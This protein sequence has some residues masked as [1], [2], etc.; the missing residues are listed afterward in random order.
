MLFLLLMFGTVMLGV[1]LYNFN[2]TPYLLPYLRDLLADYAL[3]VAVVAFSFIGSFVFSDIQR[4]ALSLLLFMD[5]NISAAMVNKL[6][7]G[8]AYHLDLLVVGLLN[9]GLSLFGLPWMHGVLP[10]SPL[11]A[12][13]L[14]DLEE[15]VDQG[16]VHGVVVPRDAL[17]GDPVARAH[18][19][20][21]PHAAL[22]V[23]QHSYRSPERAVPL[24]GGHVTYR[25]VPM[26][27]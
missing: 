4:F 5:Q 24:H 13:C 17:H 3:P 7:K 9:A 26:Q 25:F 22:P 18:R 20:V 10:H 6:K 15:R 16:H 27:C 19:T 2:K 21:A 14:A 8:T 23:V 1:F 12:R 11:Q